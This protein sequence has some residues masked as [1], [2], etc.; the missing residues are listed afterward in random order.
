MTTLNSITIMI[1][2]I[3]LVSYQ[4]MISYSVYIDYSS[5][6]HPVIFSTIDVS[7]SMYNSLISPMLIQNFFVNPQVI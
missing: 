3:N 5:I 2:S 1:A 6:F 4:I 7:T